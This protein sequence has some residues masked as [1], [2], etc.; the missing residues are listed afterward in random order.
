MARLY[1]KLDEAIIGEVP[2][3]NGP[4]TI[5]RLP[6]NTIHVDD[7]AVSGHHARIV[8]EK[9]RYVLYDENSTNGTYLNGHKVA[10]AVLSQGDVVHIA[11]HSITFSDEEVLGAED[12]QVLETSPLPI[13]ES[14]SRVEIEGVQPPA[15]PPVFAPAKP[16]V[17]IVKVLS[18]KTDQ[19]EYRLTRLQSMIGKSE[20]AAIRLTRWFAPKLVTTISLRQGKYY[21]APSQTDTPVRVNSVA[22]QNE[23]ELASGDTILV[24]DVSLFFEL[25]S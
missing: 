18:G 19:P 7:S 16:Q 4:V 11:R 22:V 15:A 12:A 14:S 25:K 1:V 6:D 2:V 13:S 9:G 24:E 3:A 8:K 23:R 5:G 10:R 17:G 20:A 21:I